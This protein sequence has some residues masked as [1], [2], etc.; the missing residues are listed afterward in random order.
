MRAPPAIG[1]EYRPSR[2][3]SACVVVLTASAVLAIALSGLPRWLA[4]TLIVLALGYGATA[5]WRFLHPR[6]LALTW[7]SDGGV[8]IRRATRGGGIEDVQGELREARVLG[9]LIALHLRWA[10]RGRASLWLLPDNL[11]GDT[12][13]RLR[14]RLGSNGIG[15]SVNADNV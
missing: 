3:I 2:A 1:F 4:I 6:V 7:R 12:R 13:R 8:S 5:L 10:P 11:D 15:A 14:V 9:F